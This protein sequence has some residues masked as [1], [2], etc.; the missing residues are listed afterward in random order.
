MY[1]VPQ[2]YQCNKCSYEEYL[3]YSFRVCPKCWEKWVKE[4][5]GWME[6]VPGVFTTS[7]QLQTIRSNSE[8][9]D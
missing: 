8:V 5:V 7:E 9:Y 1:I 2:L 6:R 4:N 3:D